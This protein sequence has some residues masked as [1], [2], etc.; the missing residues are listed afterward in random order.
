MSEINEGG[1]EVSESTEVNDT[2]PAETGGE[3]SEATQEATA[4]EANES[5]GFEDTDNTEVP[6]D[7]DEDYEETESDD[8]NT[9]S[10]D[11]GF[12]DS[13]DVDNADSRPDD[14]DFDEEDN[15]APS[16]ENRVGFD[17]LDSDCE[18]DADGGDN[19]ETSEEDVDPA[20]ESADESTNELL[21]DSNGFD[22]DTEGS[23]LDEQQE[24]DE[25]PGDPEDYSNEDTSET[26]PDRNEAD[27]NADADGKP[28]GDPNGNP[29]GDDNTDSDQDTDDDGEAQGE[30]PDAQPDGDEA[31]ADADADGEPDGNPD[32]NPDGDDNTDS[33]QDADDDGEAQS[34]DPDA[35][36]DGDEA[37]ADAD[38]DGKSDEDPDDNPD[39]DDNTDSDQDADEYR[40]SDIDDDYEEDEDPGELEQYPEDDSENRKEE[41]DSA[42]TDDETERD[43]EKEERAAEK[44]NQEAAEQEAANTESKNMNKDEANSAE[45]ENRKV[46][47]E[48]PETEVEETEPNEKIEAAQPEEDTDRTSET[49]ALDQDVDQPEPTED[50]YGEFEDSDDYR[51]EGEAEQYDDITPAEK[52]EQGTQ[53]VETSEAATDKHPLADEVSKSIEDSKN[54]DVYRSAMNNMVEYMSEHNYGPDDYAE[55]SKDPEWQKLNADLQRSLGM[56]VT[57]ETPDTTLSPESG[58]D[59]SATGLPDNCVVVNASDID[60]TYAQGMDSDQFWNHHGNTKEDYM[61]VAEKIPDVQQALDSG[62]SLDEI[63][64][65]PE[66]AG[67]ARA[68][69]DPENMIK[70]E[71]Q[72]DGSYSFTDDG[73]HRIAA[74]QEYGYQIPVEVTNMP[75]NANASNP[76]GSDIKPSS[77]S[78]SD[79]K[80]EEA[81]T[82]E[83]INNKSDVGN[84]TLENLGAFEQSNWVN[85]SQ[86]EKEKAVENLRDSIAEDLQLEQKPNIAYYNNESP[87]DY[88]GYAAST[89]TIYIN[90]FNM[91]DAAETADTIAHESRHCWQH[92]RA[93]NPQ[94]EQDYQ[95]KENFDDYVRPED[96]FYEYQNQ[97][98]EADAREYAQDIKDAIPK[99][100]GPADNEAK[101]DADGAEKNKND[102]PPAETGP[103][104]LSERKDT[105]PITE[106]PDDF[107]S[108]NR[109]VPVSEDVKKSLAESGLTESKIN[110]IRNLPKPD[111]KNGEQINRDIHKPDPKTYLNPEY[112]NKHLEPFERTG[113]F[114]IQRTDPTHPNDIYD[115]N[116]GHSSGVF[117]TSGEEMKKAVQESGGD[118][119]KMEQIF[120]LKPGELGNNPTVISFN[121]PS[122]LRMPDGNEIGALREEFIPGG[123]TSGNKA[124]AVIDPVSKGEYQVTKFNDPNLIDWIDKRGED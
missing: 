121:N 33:D 83:A 119:R 38:A 8:E 17:D 111:H 65:D 97:P 40:D 77:D 98:V 66:L 61:H 90:R 113:C 31:N 5:G 87:G 49:D 14:A 52:G 11:V 55:Y 82:P 76:D 45:S 22:N 70:V 64:Q 85:L 13:A 122:N 63:K 26:N 99:A 89:N 48:T 101:V 107:E 53:D 86:A 27:A 4:E 105:E 39:G 67:T 3:S 110:E 118:V 71:Q 88:G 92:E 93:D 108:K 37:N 91:G 81:T 43:K 15:D 20:N 79:T 42:Y 32:G 109:F 84:E 7:S 28:D 115:G 12:S 78:F 116:I 100:A 103:P 94:T 36:P 29:D 10:Q 62:K 56:E 124:E 58:K 19:S 46:T 2:P 25:D 75:E 21:D 123:F 74:A 50:E 41:N 114:K 112:I 47:E 18:N 120:G 96:D 35:Q 30:D 1:S 104:E 57:T 72:S 73:R 16:D 9:E 68:Y 117:V 51:D 34:E 6:E 80:F 23:D 95:F 54:D 102:A 69:F 60:M 44:E 24:E 106:L 59:V